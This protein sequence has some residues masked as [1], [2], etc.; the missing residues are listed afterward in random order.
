MFARIWFGL[1]GVLAG[2]KA[3]GAVTTAV[4]TAP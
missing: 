1:T 4:V 3:D 2:K